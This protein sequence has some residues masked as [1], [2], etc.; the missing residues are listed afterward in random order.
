MLLPSACNRYWQQQH[1]V[2]LQNT[3]HKRSNTSQHAGL[4]PNE[5]YSFAVA[6]YDAEHRLVSELGQSAGPVVALLPLPV[7]HCWCH[8]VLTAAQLGVAKISHLAANVVLPH[9]LV[10]QPE[11]PVWEANPLDRQNLNRSLSY[12]PST[13]L[14]HLRPGCVQANI[15]RESIVCNVAVKHATCSI[16]MHAAVIVCQGPAFDDAD[17]GLAGVIWWLPA[18]L[19]CTWCVKQSW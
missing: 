2:L 8:L 12:S 7:Y 14:L 3:V 4:Q 11:C 18:Q 1:F 5:T 19:C 6:A 13:N 15:C 9:V 10:A 17:N 16:L